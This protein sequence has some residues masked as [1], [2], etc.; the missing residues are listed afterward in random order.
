G[1][2]LLRGPLGAAELR[3]AVRSAAAPAPA[4]V[5]AEGIDG[6]HWG[7]LPAP[8]PRAYTDAQLERLR[9]LR[10][11][12]SCECPNHLAA[13]VEGLLA[14]ERYATSCANET[15]ADARLHARLADGTGKARGLMESLLAEVIRQDGLSV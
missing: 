1:A 4:P 11:S 13:I 6:E 7:A 8:P 14:F 12:L 10:S 15:V 9:N 2:A 5:P 3:R